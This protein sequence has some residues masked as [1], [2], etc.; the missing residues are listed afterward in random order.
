MCMWTLPIFL[1]GI[2]EQLQLA[3]ESFLEGDDGCQVDISKKTIKLS[4]ILKWYSVDFGRNKDEVISKTN[5]VSCSYLLLLHSAS[6]LETYCTNRVH[7]KPQNHWQ[8]NKYWIIWNPSSR[9]QLKNLTIYRHFIQLNECFELFL[10]KGFKN[11]ALVPVLVIKIQSW[12]LVWNNLNFINCNQ[13]FIR[14]IIIMLCQKLSVHLQFYYH[15]VA[16]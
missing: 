9:L 11:V 7:F 6:F 15:S 13:V 2:Y 3:A 4:Q 12:K 14:D 1:Q 5:S 8:L 10:L 16:H